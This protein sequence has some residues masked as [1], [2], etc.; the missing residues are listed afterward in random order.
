MARRPRLR[1]TRA[2]GLERQEAV[3]LQIEVERASLGEVLRQGVLSHG[4][5]MLGGSRRP[6][7]GRPGRSLSGGVAEGRCGAWVSS[8]GEDEAWQLTLYMTLMG[9]PHAREHS[10]EP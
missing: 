6:E 3:H 10:L 7:G 8:A 5:Y 2:G 1:L 9:E 4:G